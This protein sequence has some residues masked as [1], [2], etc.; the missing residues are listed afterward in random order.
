MAFL[1][2]PDVSQASNKRLQLNFSKSLIKS[3]KK[4]A[5][6]FSN[7]YL[8]YVKIIML[9]K[10]REWWPNLNK[11]LWLHNELSK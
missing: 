1:I 3:W 8:V 9:L 2:L 7:I 10:R 4:I 6:E 11:Y 5:N